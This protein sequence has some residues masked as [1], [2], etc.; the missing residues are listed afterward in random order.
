MGGGDGGGGRGGAHTVYS[1]ALGLSTRIRGPHGEAYAF[2]TGP[3]PTVCLSDEAE[4]HCC[5]SLC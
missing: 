1:V 5:A 4:R 2:A 3:F